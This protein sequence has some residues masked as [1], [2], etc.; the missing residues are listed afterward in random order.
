MPDA[1]PEPK[2]IEVLEVT[3]EAGQRVH[4]NELAQKMGISHSGDFEIKTA[5]YADE[6]EYR[7]IGHRQLL[8]LDGYPNVIGGNLVDLTITPVDDTADANEPP[9]RP[10]RPRSE[11]A[12]FG[13]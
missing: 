9:S 1:N 2:P 7:Q 13:S 6:H 12:P 8:T 11:H 10:I 4:F 5:V 3:F